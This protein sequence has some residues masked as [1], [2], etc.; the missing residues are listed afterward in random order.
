MVQVATL[1]PP[2]ARENDPP[3]AQ[4]LSRSPD[5]SVASRWRNSVQEVSRR[6]RSRKTDEKRY[7]V[8][9][10]KH[11][12]T[13]IKSVSN[14]IRF[15]VHAPSYA[16]R[17]EEE[18]DSEV[19]EKEASIEK[20]EVEAPP[21]PLPLISTPVSLPRY[22]ARPNFREI[23]KDTLASIEP[24]LKDTNLDYILEGLEHLGPQL[25]PPRSLSH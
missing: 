2:K 7:V 11:R 24:N 21:A 3:T 1:R 20:V 16:P 5:K 19:K 15:N 17:R 23:S 13:R 14:L 4:L 22:L 8:E 10:A 12:R 18:G 9:Q 25:V 6:K